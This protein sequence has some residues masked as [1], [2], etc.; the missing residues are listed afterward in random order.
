MYGGITSQLSPYEMAEEAIRKT[1]AF[2]KLA[3]LPLTL[4]EVKVV[5][6]DSFKDIGSKVEPDLQKAF[7]PYIRLTT[8]SHQQ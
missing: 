1:Y 6:H 7:V 5:S 3:G 8:S 4:P 2:I